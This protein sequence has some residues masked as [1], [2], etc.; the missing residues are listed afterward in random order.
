MAGAGEPTEEPT[1][2]R[3]RDARRRGEVAQSRELAGAAALTAAIGACAIG[4]L[5]G[6]GVLAA[7]M[8]SAIGVA[9]RGRIEDA[10]ALMDAGLWTLL[11]VVGPVLGAAAVVGG[12]ASYL[13]VGALLTFEPAQPKLERLD[14]VAGLGRM[15]SMQAFLEAGRGLLKA[16]LVA[17]VAYRTVLDRVPA[18]LAGAANPA[19][20]VAGKMGALGELALTLGV[21]G[22]GVLLL[23]G[24]AD[25]LLKRRAYFK[26][27]RMTR[28]EVKRE[29]KEEEGDPRHKAERRRQ[30]RR[31]LQEAAMRAVPRA[32]VVITNPS[33]VAVALRYDRDTMSAPT[34]TA[35]GEGRIAA[36]IRS[37]ARKHGVP[38]RREPALARA[39]AE[40]EIDET[41]PEE[42]YDAV[43]EVL[44]VVLARTEGA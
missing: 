11:A 41:I 9:V 8:R 44:R 38:I 27:L 24:G 19:A 31:L 28:E 2:K 36:E 33:H 13:Q 5:A 1:P 12:L 20:P 21:R 10:P 3:L 30:H 4:A 18:L 34:V 35:K 16:G 40:I 7:F 39:L 26:K 42:L 17:W 22:G 15:F 25:Y 29:H 14:P 37:L 43:A 32:H 23:C 6:V